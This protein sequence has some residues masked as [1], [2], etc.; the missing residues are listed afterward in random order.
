MQKN[1]NTQHAMT[2]QLRTPLF[3]FLGQGSKAGQGRAG[4]RATTS[5][6]PRRGLW[7]VLF[8]DRVEGFGFGFGVL[9]FGFR[10][11]GLGFRV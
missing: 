6:L 2:Q 1:A 5:R 9:G 10:V 11:W 8:G 7:S 4:L 3:F